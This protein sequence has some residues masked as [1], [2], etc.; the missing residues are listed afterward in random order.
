MHALRK[1]GPGFSISL[2]VLV[3]DELDTGLLM[4]SYEGS[5][6]SCSSI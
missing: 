2:S 5:K 6:P 4:D 3:G 1:T